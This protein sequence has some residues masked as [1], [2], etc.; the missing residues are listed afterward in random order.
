V[1]PRDKLDPVFQRAIQACRERTLQH[2]TLPAEENSRSSMTNKSWSGY[3]WY[4][5][6]YRS[7][8]Q[9]NTDLRSTSIA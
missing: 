5:G 6:S 1:I 8:I 2:V 7:L 4:Q 9:V 3:N